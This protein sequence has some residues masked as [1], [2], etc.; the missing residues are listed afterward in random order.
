MLVWVDLARVSKRHRSRRALSSA[1]SGSTSR[2]GQSEL[3]QGAKRGCC[4]LDVE[5]CLNCESW[6]GAFPMSQRDKARALRLP[7]RRDVGAL[8]DMLIVPLILSTAVCPLSPS[9]RN[10]S[11]TA[12]IHQI[13]TPRPGP[14]SECRSMRAE[15]TTSRKR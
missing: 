5:F 2:S 8:R 10:N 7:L 9:R 3:C 1:M 13:R 14:L 15:K 12:S 6:G 11:E 4:L